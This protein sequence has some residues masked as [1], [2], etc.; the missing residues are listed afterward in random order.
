MQECL[1]VGG[2]GG[3]LYV[4]CTSGKINIIPLPLTHG[5]L[6]RTRTDIPH[7]T[8]DFLAMRFPGTSHSTPGLLAM[9]FSGSCQIKYTYTIWQSPLHQHPM[10]ALITPLLRPIQPLSLGG[11]LLLPCAVCAAGGPTYMVRAHTLPRSLDCE[12][13]L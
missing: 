1:C 10:H 2:I 11:G 4:P 3:A 6:L 13:F 7:W 8:T 5:P 9:R 12:A